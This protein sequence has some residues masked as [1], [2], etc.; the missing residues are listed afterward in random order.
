MVLKTSF[1]THM[2]QGFWGLKYCWGFDGGFFGAFEIEF[3][4]V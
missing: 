4:N 1:F 2:K 3:F